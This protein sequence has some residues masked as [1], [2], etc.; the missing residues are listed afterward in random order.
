MAE[1][2]EGCQQPIREL[3]GDHMH[4]SADGI[5]S[6]TSDNG[7]RSG[8]SCAAILEKGYPNLRN[9]ILEPLL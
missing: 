9:S 5:P 3:H 6:M 8:I 1:I 7:H 2:S 4:Q